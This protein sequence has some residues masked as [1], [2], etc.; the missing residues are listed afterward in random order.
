MIVYSF[1]VGSLEPVKEHFGIQRQLG[2]SCLV[3]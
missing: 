1:Q 3:G 2:E